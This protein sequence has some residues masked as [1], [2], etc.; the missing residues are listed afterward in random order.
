MAWGTNTVFELPPGWETKLLE[1]NGQGIEVLQKE[2]DTC[3]NEFMVGITGQQVTTTGGSGFANAE[4][5]NQIRE[6]LIE[7]DAESLAYTVN[8]QGL[9]SYIARNYGGWG[10]VTSRAT[11]VRWVTGKPKELSDQ[12][13]TLLQTA[14]AIT[15]LLQALAVSGRELDINALCEQFAIPLVDTSRGADTSSG[16]QVRQVP[17]K[18]L[19]LPAKPSSEPSPEA[20]ALVTAMG[21]KVAA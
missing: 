20:K 7:Q 3:D 13:K 14:Q 21:L 18:P 11:N 5:P 16:I 1:S 6:D 8:T 17:P 4:F 15:A 9:P 19:A 10:E 2:I 12:S